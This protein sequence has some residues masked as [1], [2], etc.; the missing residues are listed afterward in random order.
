MGA[1]VFILVVRTALE[2]D[3]YPNGSSLSDDSRR[4]VRC[5]REGKTKW[6]API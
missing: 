2:R 6:G 1:D 4:H 5:C 3:V